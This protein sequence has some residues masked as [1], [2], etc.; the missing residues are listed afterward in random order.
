MTL[1]FFK[2]MIDTWI[3]NFKENYKGGEGMKCRIDEI[4]KLQRTIA[5]AH[6]GSGWSR[7]QSWLRSVLWKAFLA[8]SFQL[9]PDDGKQ[10]KVIR[11]EEAWCLSNQSMLL[12]SLTTN[13]A[14][15]VS[16]D[17]KDTFWR[18]ITSG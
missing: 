6:Q 8:D 11:T 2:T 14:V 13:K 10:D 7:M 15:I 3:W 4:A 9:G 12:I 17:M 16:V 5:D 18:P 1:K